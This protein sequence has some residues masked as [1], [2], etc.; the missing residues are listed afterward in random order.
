MTSA[1][2]RPGGSR[3]RSAGRS[4][5]P[6]P[7]LSAAPGSAAGDQRAR[8]RRRASRLFVLS[9]LPRVLGRYAVELVAHT[10]TTAG[11]RAA[12]TAP[13]RARRDRAPG[14]RRRVAPKRLG[15]LELRR[16]E[17]PPLPSLIAVL[18]RVED[19]RPTDV[20]LLGNDTVKDCEVAAGY[21]LVL[22]QA[23]ALGISLAAPSSVTARKVYRVLLAGPIATKDTGVSTSALIGLYATSGLEGI[24]AIAA[25]QLVDPR[26]IHRV[27]VAVAE[28]GGV[29]ATCPGPR[30]MPRRRCGQAV[31]RRSPRARR[32]PS[33]ATT[34]PGRCVR[35]GPGL[36]A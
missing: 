34:R 19:P 27:E 12:R 20:T 36:C 6:A 18:P 25:S 17:D 21:H 26:E 8:A 2:R 29:L 13:G 10:R 24:R 32:S 4:P 30:S 31:C 7:R 28:L 16:R 3:R 23:A 22:A 14:H 9:G 15:V 33:S 5:E 35:P 11:A 1:A